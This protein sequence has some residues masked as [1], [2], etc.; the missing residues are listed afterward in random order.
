MEILSD[1]YCFCDVRNKVKFRVWE[2]RANYVFKES[3][4]L[5]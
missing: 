4:S 2:K 5:Q 3:G 1:H